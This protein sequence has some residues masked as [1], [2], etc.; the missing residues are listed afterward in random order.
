MGE[1]GTTQIATMYYNFKETQNKAFF[2]WYREFR[3]RLEFVIE[4]HKTETILSS[5]KPNSQH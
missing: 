3:Q 4:R 2:P 1:V 5:G